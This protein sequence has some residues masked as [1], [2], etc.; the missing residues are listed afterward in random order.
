[1]WELNVSGFSPNQKSNFLN[2]N[3]APGEKFEKI[4]MGQ[5]VGVELLGHRKQKLSFGK[6]SPSCCL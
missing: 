3:H 5:E 4:S 2:L 6:Q 1:L